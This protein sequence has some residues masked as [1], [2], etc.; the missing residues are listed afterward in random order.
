MKG[1]MQTHNSFIKLYDENVLDIVA[2]D[3]NVMQNAVLSIINID[4]DYIVDERKKF[5]DL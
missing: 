4:F 3:R 2:D 5:K 1:L